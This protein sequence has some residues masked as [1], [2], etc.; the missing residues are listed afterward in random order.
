MGRGG[1]GFKDEVGNKYGKLLVIK[2]VTNNKAGTAKW[3]CKCD[4]GNTK[5]VLGANLRDGTI[6]SCGCL[7]KEAMFNRRK[8]DAVYR[9]MY[10]NIQ[11]DCRNREIP[12][13]ITLEDVIEI[14]H[15]NCTYCK[16]E[17]YDRRCRYQKVNSIAEDD[18]LIVNGVDRVIPSKGYTKGNV[19]PCCKYCNRA[20]SDLSL[21]EFKNLITLIYN[22]Y[23]DISN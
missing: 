5:E 7:Q 3:E 4:C 19:V 22:N 6:K 8:G 20:K 13:N 14:A 23:V 15:K 21:E 16:R 12:F 18:C 11:S 2:R 1:S 9:I 17:P 10:R